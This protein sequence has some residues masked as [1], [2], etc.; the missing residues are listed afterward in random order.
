[1]VETQIAS[2]TE[3]RKHFVVNEKDIEELSIRKTKII[4]I[5]LFPR[6]NESCVPIEADVMWIIQ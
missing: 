4:D 1:M 3:Q 5:G 6:K 2:A